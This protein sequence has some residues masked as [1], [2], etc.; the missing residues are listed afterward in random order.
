MTFHRSLA[1]LPLLL[2]TGSAHAQSLEQMAG[3]MIVV[4]FQGDDAEDAS[5]VALREEL[6]AGKIG[7]VMYLKTNVK[8]L[9]AVREMNAAFR[10]ASPELLPFITLD[11]EGG[12][13][14]RL[15]ADVGFAEIPSAASIASANTP[16][17]AETIYG[18][19]A[20]LIA[21]LGFSVNFGPV[22]DVN[23]NPN[24]QVIAKFGRAYSADPATVA[25]YDEAFV[26]AH[27]AAGLLTAP[28][29]FPGHGSSTADSH[30]GFVDITQ[31]WKP[32][33]LVPYKTL[34]A[35]GLVDMI[36]VGH[37]YHA[38]HSESD[39]QNPAS[40]SKRWISGILRGDMKYNGV[41]ISDDLEMG[42]IRDH[43][44]LEETVTKAV[45]AGMDI[46]LFSNTAQYRA[47]LGQE[48]LDILL[49]EA[50]A[51]PEFKALIETSYQRIVALKA[52]IG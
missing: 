22:A 24:N 11:Q 8:S 25:A 39:A 4:G 21:E 7:G 27:H 37:L 31:S 13:V 2:M 16:E 30:E 32:E 10:S 20:K 48:I 9:D 17:Q 35:D 49:A 3:Q 45:R 41:V 1:I 43:F 29:H 6:A 36:M 46:L 19:M 42:A 34:M 40:L 47:G 12:S 5:V 52:R 50:Q 26:R 38:A 51:D 28:K 18:S 23:L 44:T 15:T 33:E 14:E